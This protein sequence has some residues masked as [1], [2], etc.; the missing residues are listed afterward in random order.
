MNYKYKT[1]KRLLSKSIIVFLSVM[2]FYLERLNVFAADDLSTA[3]P[4]KTLTITLSIFSGRPNPEW[5]LSDIDAKK[6]NQYT[7]FISTEPLCTKLGYRGFIINF[8]DGKLRYIHAEANPSL[9]KWL[10]STA[11]KKVDHKIIDSVYGILNK[12]TQLLSRE[13]MYA[14]FVRMFPRLNFYKQEDIHPGYRLAKEYSE[15]LKVRVESGE[16]E[17]A[18]ILRNTLFDI[19]TTG[20]CWGFSKKKQVNRKER[21]LG[22]AALLVLSAAIDE[23]SL[24][25]LKIFSLRDSETYPKRHIRFVL[26]TI[27]ANREKLT[28]SKREEKWEMEIEPVF[29]RFRLEYNYDNL[30]KKEALGKNPNKIARIKLL[31]ETKELIEADNVFIG[32]CMDRFILYWLA[33]KLVKWKQERERIT[34]EKALSLEEIEAYPE[35]LLMEYPNVKSLASDFSQEVGDLI[36]AAAK[37]RAVEQFNA[38]RI[39]KGYYLT[40]GVY[41]Y[42]TTDNDLTIL[43]KILPRVRSQNPL[44]IKLMDIQE[45]SVVRNVFP[46]GVIP[47]FGTILSVNMPLKQY[48][49]LEFLRY[50]RD[51]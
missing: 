14:D 37:V 25:N 4:I 29:R 48:L 18:K 13:Q 24:D 20:S 43:F 44:S 40:H 17:R 8:S 19:F 6:F 1:N 45:V 7:Q 38:G 28:S 30:E 42:S 34:G 41:S 11:S 12:N 26:N 23:E 51:S 15:E 49:N 16:F 50:F 36:E 31:S 33:P 3:E 22:L 5:D 47:E 46:G 2:F 35:G 10:L 32:N 21:E 9:E 27:S 39:Y